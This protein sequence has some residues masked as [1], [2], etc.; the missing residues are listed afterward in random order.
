MR[1]PFNLTLLLSLCVSG[2]SNA[3][4][5][6][7]HDIA[8]PESWRY[9]HDASLSINDDAPSINSDA[10]WWKSFGSDEL[11]RLI[12]HAQQ[13]NLDVQAAQMR[14][15]QADAL[16]RVAG[17][18]LYPQLEGNLSAGREGKLRGNFDDD[19]LEGNHFTLGLNASYELD[20]WGV[21]RARKQAARAEFEASIYD[22]AT[23]RLSVTAAVAS[24]WLQVG[25]MRERLDIARLNLANAEKVLATVESRYRYGAALPLELAQQR[26][27]VAAQ[28]YDLVELQQRANDSEMALSVLLAMPVQTLR[29]E[30]N[31]LRELNRPAI[32]AGVP[33]A[34]LVRRPDIARAEARLNAASANFSAARAALW[35]SLTLNA[36]V[37]ASNDRWSHLFDQQLYQLA[38]SLAAPIFNG[39]RLRAQRD[40][41]EAQM[42]ELLINYRGNLIAALRDVDTSLNAL[43]GFALQF[44]AQNEQLRQAQLAFDFAESRYQAGADT[45]IVLLDAQRTL[46]AAQ[47]L[48]VRI[49]EAQLQATVALYKSLG[50]GWHQP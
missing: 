14:L 18:A 33:S 36:G 12:E 13:Q 40:L 34:L 17:A 6:P 25:A 11:N 49:R 44:E 15:Q 50:G 20:L 19:E 32:G 37:A 28:K 27:V 46:Y 47:D 10:A 4:V 1:Y 24:A 3:P 7:A 31:S 2:C 42:L 8:L 35:P 41:A 45:L 9:Q 23:V 43:D 21:N 29:V 16:V 30:A 39:G 48:N 26:G 5:T 22:L 38:G